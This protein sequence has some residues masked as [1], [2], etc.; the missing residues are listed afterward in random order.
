MDYQR[1]FDAA[2]NLPGAP[3]AHA[4]GGK[5]PAT[6]KAASGQDGWQGDRR[7]GQVYLYYQPKVELAVNIALK[8]QRPLLLLGPSGSGKSSLAMNVARRLGRRYCEATI[9]SNMTYGD[10][11]CRFDMVRRLGDAQASGALK[12]DDHYIEPGPLWWAFDPESAARRGHAPGAADPPPA[13]RD[14]SPL[15]GAR[16]VL[17][18]DEIDKAE[19]DVPNN[20]LVALGSFRFDL[21]WIG[22]TVVAA[23]GAP[24]IV[25]TSNN[26]RELPPAFIRRCIVLHLEAPSRD[27]LVQIAIAHFGPSVKT[28]A[29]QVASLVPDA[30]PATRNT[31]AGPSTAEYLD[32]V[33]ACR[34]LGIRPSAGDGVWEALRRV[35]WDK[36][37]ARP[38]GGTP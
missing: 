10:L 20:L 34:E 7:D 18:L 38:E 4:A 29:Q 11:I 14:P 12:P 37:R 19:P 16:A 27:S 15:A 5:R 1:E 24:L 32:A 3:G 6:R 26:E 30:V 28:L 25:I 21:P 36:S 31:E 35:V 23:G 9:T 17:L 13:A 33:K 8:T 22:Q 2:A